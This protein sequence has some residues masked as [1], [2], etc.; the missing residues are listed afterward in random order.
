MDMEST[1][2][3]L[4]QSKV[5]LRSYLNKPLLILHVSQALFRV[6][7]HVTLHTKILSV[8][9]VH[10]YTILKAVEFH[11][12]EWT[13]RWSEQW[14]GEWMGA[15]KALD[16]SFGNDV[17]NGNFLWASA[18]IGNPGHFHHGVLWFPR[19]FWI[20]WEN[21]TL[22]L[23]VGCRVPTGSMSDLGPWDPFGNVLCK[24]PHFYLM[25]STI[26]RFAV[27]FR[28]DWNNPDVVSVKC[29][30]FS[31]V[32]PV[33]QNGPSIWNCSKLGHYEKFNSLY[34]ASP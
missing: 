14:Q 10:A 26:L 17:G 21:A 6:C 32:P 28:A 15:L 29:S 23:K 2:S 30:F 7:A 1:F 25:D 12:R 27:T 19:T 3:N 9:V 31:T 20:H 8:I 13:R 22:W 5:H 34:H 24:F 4:I 18:Y 11:G 16:P 33:R